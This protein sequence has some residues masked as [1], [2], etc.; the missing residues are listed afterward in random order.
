[1]PYS[2][3]M[4]EMK[5]NAMLN[6]VRQLNTLGGATVPAFAWLAPLVVG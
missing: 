1:M 5:A 6:A 4:G 3:T 2:A